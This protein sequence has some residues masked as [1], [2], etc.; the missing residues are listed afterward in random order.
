MGSDAVQQVKNALASIDLEGIGRSIGKAV[1]DAAR[2]LGL[3]QDYTSPYIIHDDSSDK[4][5]L[6]STVRGVILLLVALGLIS[7]GVIGLVVNTAFGAVLGAGGAVSLIAGIRGVKRGGYEKRLGKAVDDMAHKLGAR[8]SVA[9]N[10]L[11]RLVDTPVAELKPLV[12]TAIERGLI[13]EG[14]LDSSNKGEVLYLS[15]GAWNAEL[16]ARSTAQSETS[17]RKAE[18]ATSKRASNGT[19][20]LPH[21]AFEVVQACASFVASIKAS[22]APLHDAETRASLEGIAQKVEQLAVYVR[23]HPETAPQLRKLVTYYLPTT[24]KL[25]ESYAELERLGQSAQTQSTRDELKETL[26]LI[27]DALAKLS[28]TLLQEQS[29]D[30]KSDMDVMR[31]MLKQDGLAD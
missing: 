13:P 2:Q 6:A 27:D 11:A 31:Q 4:H 25:A 1:G 24:E 3:V 16:E 12:R 28:A 21:D 10:E 19:D 20:G 8:Q 30:L 14:H 22:A 26:R 5:A 17:R 15:R 9:L 18:R 23:K 7:V 29:W